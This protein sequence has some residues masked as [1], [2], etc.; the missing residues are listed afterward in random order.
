MS[1]GCSNYSQLAQRG[2]P[3]FSQKSII[4]LDADVD[5]A[6][7]KKLHT[8][9]LLPGIL[10]PDQLLFEYLFNLPAS[11]EIWTNPQQITRPVFTA[12]ASDLIRE[13]SIST[14]SID[15]KTLVETYRAGDKAKKEKLREYF[16]AFYK[17]PDIQAFVAQKKASFNPWRS[18]MQANDPLKTQFISQFVAKLRKIMADGFSV[19]SSKLGIFDGM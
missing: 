7:I 18:W 2:V 15:V 17:A 10:P 16:K 9:V 11:H 6:K 13:L 4:C 19:D 5:A 12:A 3:E 1:L 14:A 8:I